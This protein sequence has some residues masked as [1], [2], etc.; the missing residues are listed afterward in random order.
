M[1]QYTLLGL[2]VGAIYAISALGLVSVY[3][4]SRVVNLAH[5]GIALWGAYIFLELRDKHGWNGAPAAAASIALA[6]TAGVVLYLLV[7]RLV[8]TRTELLKLVVSLGVLVFLQG[9]ARKRIGSDRVVASSLPNE[10]IDV[11]GATI[12]RDRLILLAI[13]LAIAV[14]LI[15]W[16]RWS[17]LALAT[18]ALAR[19]EEATV[20]LGYSPTVLGS[21]NW[22]L[23][24]ALAALSGILI[25]PISGFGVRGVTVVVVPALAAALVGRFES[26][27]AAL[28]GGLALGIAEVQTGLR[29]DTP[30]WGSAA[31]FVLSV[32]VLLARRQ[33]GLNRLGSLQA[34]AMAPSRLR[35]PWIVASTVVAVA[36]VQLSDESRVDTLIGSGTIALF[37]LS[38]MVLIGLANQISLAQLAIAGV[39]ALVAARLAISADVPFAIA[40][41]IGAAAGA[42]IGAIVGLPSLRVR[43]INLAVVTIGLAVAI[44]KVIF[45]NADYTGGYNGLQPDPPTFFGAD[46]E[47]LSHPKAYCYVVFGWLALAMAGVA[48]LR[49]S[50]LGRQLHVVRTNERAAAAQGIN[51]AR[52]KI[53]AFTIS[54]AIAGAAGV[55]MAFRQRTLSFSKFGLFSSIELIAVSVLGG[56]GAIAGP[57]VTGLIA[58]GGLLFGELR[59]W[60]WLTSNS[61][62]IFGVS[63]VFAAWRNPNGITAPRRDVPEVP[64]IPDAE[65]SATVRGAALEV[66][67]LGVAYGGVKAVNGATVSVAPGEI[68]GLIGPNGAGKTTVLDAISGFSPTTSGS[69][70]FDGVDL[71]GMGPSQ[72]ARIGIGRVFQSLELFEDLSLAG[73]LQISA[74]QSLSHRGC[75]GPAAREFIDANGLSADL[76]RRPTELSMGRRAIVALARALAPSPRILLLDEPAAGLSTDESDALVTHLRTIAAQ[77]IGILLIDHD[78]QVV[79]QACDRI[80]VLVNGEN[81]VEGTPAEIAAHPDVRTVYLGTTASHVHH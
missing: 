51:V 18:L 53:L 11:L 15:I 73:N 69:I 21:L 75:L 7:F 1:I 41:L 5:G 55:L 60:G 49:R 33:E 62:L 36:M 6:A 10:P 70:V 79:L 81:L 47:A 24:S 8:R 43:G 56:M 13:G 67:D 37:A 38:L 39:G 72:R 57:L 12:G 28:A 45:E 58:P 59:D 26:Y 30:G 78:M 16:S 29:I 23:G 54:S 25:V 74:D 32:I 27:G 52:T 42:V 76:G 34:L 31:P 65:V 61:S 77:G 22:A 48:A 46:V 17:R 14:A 71:D 66:R 2:G 63:V 40:P 68:V 35:W 9:A 80:V 64:V 20:S 3:R 44:E 50:R 19:H 4:G